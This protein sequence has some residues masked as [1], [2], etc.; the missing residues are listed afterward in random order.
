MASLKV[1]TINIW[2]RQGPWEQRL[3]LLRAGVRSLDA[4][5]I[6]LQEVIAHAS[7]SQANMIAEGLGYQVAFGNAHDLGEGVQFGNAV[8]SRWPIARTEAF[9]LPDAGTD[10][11]RS[12]VLAEIDSPYG[13][14]PFF[15]THLNWKFHHGFAR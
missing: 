4:D 12:L 8:L 7:F 1:L 2:N 9:P 15:S 3:E 13:V 10:E 14:I 11:S 6:G 5:V